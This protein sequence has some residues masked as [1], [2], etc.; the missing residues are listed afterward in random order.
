VK[1]TGWCRFFT[2]HDESI[3][4]PLLYIRNKRNTEL[5][6]TRGG[7]VDRNASA[8]TIVL[9][10]GFDVMQPSYQTV[11]RRNPARSRRKIDQKSFRSSR[12]NTLLARLNRR[13]CAGIIG[14]PGEAEQGRL[15]R[16]GIATSVA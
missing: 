3:R 2:T 11:P 6:K 5:S 9:P 15:S 16:D 4:Q 13:F 8:L 10:D 14:L 7:R 1:L 12:P